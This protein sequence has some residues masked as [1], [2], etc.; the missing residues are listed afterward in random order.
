MNHLKLIVLIL[1]IAIPAWAVDITVTLEWDPVVQDPTNMN[2]AGEIE[3]YAVYVCEAPIPDNAGKNQGVS[4][5]EAVIC[6]ATLATYTTDKVRSDGSGYI[7]GQVD[8]PGE[9]CSPDIVIHTEAEDFDAGAPNDTFFDTTPGDRWNL[10]YR[11][12]PHDVD[13][14]K[15]PFNDGPFW[16]TSSNEPGEWTRFTLDIRRAGAYTPTMHMSNDNKELSRVKLI[17]LATGKEAEFVKPII[18]TDTA[19]PWDAFVTVSSQPSTLPFTVGRHQV[20]LEIMHRSSAIDWFKLTKLGRVGCN[21]IPPVVYTLTHSTSSSTGTLFVRTASIT[22]DGDGRSPFSN[23][24]EILIEEV[25][26][27]LEVPRHLRVK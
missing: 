16:A 22:T 25:N 10:G 5:A 12:D 1:S 14:R 13:I 3:R 2:L 11:T 4:E 26:R 23:Q 9:D 6:G 19:D 7:E 15:I 18:S 8:E 21:P 24:I 17:V 27:R 20:R